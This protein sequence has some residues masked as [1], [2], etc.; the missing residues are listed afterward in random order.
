MKLST[1]IQAVDEEVVGALNYFHL[2]S[3]LTS[4][5][6]AHFSSSAPNVTSCGRSSLAP[7]YK[8]NDVLA[9]TFLARSFSGYAGAMFQSN[10]LGS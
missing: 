7:L 8:H 1:R 10:V 3:I 5:L 2:S 4:M 9:R 6:G